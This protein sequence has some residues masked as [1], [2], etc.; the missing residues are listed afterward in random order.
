MFLIECD[1]SVFWSARD[2]DLYCWE[3]FKSNFYIIFWMFLVCFNHNEKFFSCLLVQIEFSNRK[4]NTK[5]NNSNSK[6]YNANGLLMKKDM[7]KGGR[8]YLVA[9]K[10]RSW[11]IIDSWRWKLSFVKWEQMTWSII[12]CVCVLDRN[13]QETQQ[14]NPKKNKKFY[15]LWIWWKKKWKQITTTDRETEKLKEQNTK[16][17][18]RRKNVETFLHF[19]STTK[20]IR[21][22]LFFFSTKLIPFIFTFNI[23]VFIFYFFFRGVGN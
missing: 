5:N 23:F 2:H 7:R 21:K 6:I 12:W 19:F 9:L 17:Q 1:N 11:L 3:N 15:F 18:E 16:K 20:N 10:N 4:D 22:K 13:V 14:E 8:S